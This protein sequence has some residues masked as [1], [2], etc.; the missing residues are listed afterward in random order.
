MKRL[1]ISNYDEHKKKELMIYVQ[2]KMA[3]DIE[4][5]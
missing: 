4:K 3:S 1:R 2:T 5:A